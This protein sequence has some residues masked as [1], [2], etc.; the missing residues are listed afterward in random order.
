MA[1]KHAPKDKLMNWGNAVSREAIALGD[2]RTTKTR[3]LALELALRSSKVA[4]GAGVFV[5]STE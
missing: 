1:F 5:Y 2:A 3:K 4:T